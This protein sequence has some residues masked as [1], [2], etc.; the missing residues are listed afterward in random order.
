VSELLIEGGFGSPLRRDAG[1]SWLAP[2]DV[3]FLRQRGRGEADAVETVVAAALAVVRDDDD[4][5]DARD[6]DDDARD[7]DG[8]DDDDDDDASETASETARVG[9][10]VLGPYRPLWPSADGPLSRPSVDV[11]RVD[12]TGDGVDVADALDGVRER[13]V[14]EGTTTRVGAVVL[15]NPS[16]VTG[17]LA[18]VSSVVKASAWCARRG[19]HLVVDETNFA[20]ASTDAAMKFRARGEEEETRAAAAAAAA[21]R[22]NA[23]TRN[24]K[25]W[26]RAAGFVSASS[27]WR[28][29]DDP[30]VHVVAAFG[31]AC[32]LARGRTS[33]VLVTRDEATRRRA[34]SDPFAQ[35]LTMLF[36]DGG[37]AAREA[38]GH[39]VDVVRARRGE[40]LELLKPLL[41][42]GKISVD[43]GDVMIG[44]GL[45]L[46]VDCGG[47]YGG[48]GRRGTLEHEAELFDAFAAARVL[49]VPG[50][51]CGCAR[52][53]MFRVTVAG[54]E[55]TVVEG[56]KRFAN[57][58]NVAST[59]V[60]GFVRLC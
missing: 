20:A 22:P 60:G 26:G 43:D 2:D 7:D 51:L 24:P 36:G 29:D 57:V 48:D 55:A 34:G 16:P 40:V 15:S 13:F 58:V 9:V 56:V 38:F 37:T 23:E 59:P 5:D 6:D 1:G 49:V 44:G 19:A 52:P 27:L 11:V 53:G 50:T 39:H 35:S 41:A 12:V 3:S 30:R 42:S 21:K 25:P 31:A 17:A 45:A 32:G 8:D 28:D 18:R 46:W 14:R 10:V 33:C 47:G 54:D 4:G